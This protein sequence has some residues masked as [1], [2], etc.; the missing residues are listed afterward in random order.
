MPGS[1]AKERAAG[2]MAAR[3]E[4]RATPGARTA[5]AFTL[6]TSVCESAWPAIAVKTTT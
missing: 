3:T 4:S 6:R 1:T 2:A 5:A